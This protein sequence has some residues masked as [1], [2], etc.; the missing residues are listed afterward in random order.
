MKKIATVTV[1]AG[2]ASS[3]DFTSIPQTY[4]DLLLVLSARTSFG[5]TLDSLSLFINGATSAGRRVEGSGNGAAATG[6]AASYL[7]T[8]YI[9][10]GGSTANNF[11][12]TSIYIPN[13]TAAIAKSWSAESVMENNSTAAYSTIVGGF[14]SNTSATTSVSLGSGSGSLVQYSTATLYGITKGTL[15][16]I[17][18]S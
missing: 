6:N 8:G 5:G 1:G 12:V 14:C 18:V 13:Y 16:G 15:A 10:G 11:S 17:T 9:N 7:M 3:I 2:G 4:T